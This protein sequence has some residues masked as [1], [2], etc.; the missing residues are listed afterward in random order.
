MGAPVMIRIAVPGPSASGTL[1]ARDSPTTGSGT[2]VSGEAAAM[3]F[4]RTAYPSIAE[5]SNPGRSETDDTDSA[6]M[7]PSASARVT[8]S[9][10]S[11]RTPSSSRLCALETDSRSGAATC[12]NNLKS[13]SSRLKRGYSHH[14][15]GLR[16]GPAGSLL[17]S[18]R[19]V[20]APG[21]RRPAHA[22]PKCDTVEDGL[23][24]LLELIIQAFVVHR[25]ARWIV[26]NALGRGASEEGLGVRKLARAQLRKSELDHRAGCFRVCLNRV[27]APARLAR[28]QDVT[29]DVVVDHTE[30]GELRG[31]I[32]LR[33]GDRGE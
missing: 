8:V 23:Q 32:E 11:T 19:I 15:R 3:S 10:V 13:S 30:D 20:P 4:A 31:C 25:R 29:D 27:A 17:S 33:I 18:V 7:R 24:A 22:H 6:R 16:S 1:P 9:G 2:G 28:V 21:G 14:S 5:F 26:E 12:V